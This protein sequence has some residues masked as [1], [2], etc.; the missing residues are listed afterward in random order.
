M[1]KN[2]GLKLYGAILGDLAGQ[3]YEYKYKGDFSE[4][5]I[6]DPKSRI[7]DDTIMTIATASKLLGNFKSF[8][9]AYRYFGQK[10]INLDCFGSYFERWLSTPEGTTGS[11]YG[12][13][14]LMRLSPIMYSRPYHSLEYVKAS[15]LDSCLN[16]HHHPDS[17]KSCLNLHKEY[18]NAGYRKYAT[19]HKPEH[20][21]SKFTKFEVSAVQ[22]MKFVT[23]AFWLCEN[24]KQAIE[25]VVKLGGDTDTNASIVGELMNFTFN[26]L[27][28]EDMQY[29]ESKL[30]P[31]LLKILLDFNKKF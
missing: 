20:F 13:G 5:K 9:E 2:Y 29:V 23:D 3:P 8:E 7:T 27:T 17:V 24:T 19:R 25:K 28:Q 15:V 22:T 12:N 11:S 14:C 26:D 31:Y 6:H 30:D 18:V 4:F 16:S 1:Y 10:Y 21:V